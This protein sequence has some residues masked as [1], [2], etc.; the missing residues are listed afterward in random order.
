MRNKKIRVKMMKIFFGKNKKQHHM[1]YVIDQHKIS[2]KGF[3]LVELIVVLTISTILLGLT[4]LGIIAWQDWSTF[5]KQNEY[6]QSLFVAAQNQLTEYGSNG[7]LESVANEM[8][9]PTDHS[10]VVGKELTKTILEE[11]V[12]GEKEDG[13]VAHYS[14][15]AIWPESVAKEKPELYQDKIV[16]ITADATQYT[17]YLEDPIAF[18]KDRKNEQAYW[19]FEL[20]GEYIYDSSILEKGAISIEFTPEDGQVF[21]AFYSE[22]NQHFMYEG[23]AA[24]GIANLCDRS[25]SARRKKMVGFYGV[26]SLY[27]STDNKLIQA[28]ISKLFLHNADTEYLTFKL[29]KH[30]EA[31]QLL[32]YDVT[33]YEDASNQQR[34]SFTLDGTKIKNAEHAQ[35]SVC[36][37][38]RNEPVLD[39]GAVK[40]DGNGNVIYKTEG[41]S[42]G[43]FPILAYIEK[44]KTVRILFDAADVQATT[45]LYKQDLDK[46]RGN[47]AYGNAKEEQFET[48]TQVPLREFAGT[49][50]FF[51]FGIAPTDIYVSV[52][53]HGTGFKDTNTK[54]SNTKNSVFESQSVAQGAD[55]KQYAFGV[56]NGRHLY[57]IRYLEDLT[58]EQQASVTTDA[59]KI[60]KVSFALEGDIDF[61]KFQREDR[62]L[63]NSRVSYA[64]L[65]FP[66]STWKGKLVDI[67]KTK[68]ILNEDI[69]MIETA[70]DGS[71][72]EFASFAQLRSKDVLDGK[73]KTISGIYISELSNAYYGVYTSSVGTKLEIAEKKP[74]GL[75]NINLGE[76]KDLSLDHIRVSGTDMIGGFCGVNA[77]VAS[78]LETAN[79]NQKSK[80]TG[81]SNVGGLIGFQLPTSKQVEIKGLKNRV[82]VEGVKAVGGILGMVRNEFSGI[83]IAKIPGYSS[84][85]AAV[86]SK[87]EELNIQI[88]ECENYGSVSG[89][90]RDQIKGLWVSGDIDD[91]PV[92][93]ETAGED[94]REIRSTEAGYVGGIVGYC[95]NQFKTVTSTQDDTSKIQVLSCVSSPELDE[96]TLMSI[97]EDKTVDPKGYTKLENKQNGVYIGG[98]VGYNHYGQIRMCSTRAEK[99]KEGYLFGYRYVGGIVGLN[100]GPASGII[101]SN[102]AENEKGTNENHIVAY[103][104]AGGIT[105]CNANVRL[106]DKDGNDISATKL[107][108]EKLTTVL[109]PDSNRSLYVKIDNWINKG[110]V[111]ATNQYSGGITGYNA[112]MIFGCNSEVEADVADR[113]FATLYSGDYAGGV[114]GYN[115]GV[116]GNTV[117][118]IADNA[119]DSTVKTVGEKFSTV[120]YVKGHN[121]VG[122]IV[123]YNDVDSILEDYEIASGY[124]LGDAGSCFVGGY[125]GLNASIDLLMDQTY[126]KARMIYSNPNKVEGSYC[127]GGNIG[128]NMINTNGFTGG[129][130]GTQPLSSSKGDAEDSLAGS[131]FGGVVG[132]LDP[133]VTSALDAATRNT[134]DVYASFGEFTEPSAPGFSCKGKLVIHNSEERDICG[135][136][137]PVKGLPAGT[138]IAFSNDEAQYNAQNGMIFWKDKA[139]CEI[140]TATKEISFTVTGKTLEAVTKAVATL[141]NQNGDGKQTVLYALAGD[142]VQ[143][144]YVG[145]T[146]K[147]N[148]VVFAYEK[149]S[150]DK[151]TRTLKIKM[152]VENQTDTALPNGRIDFKIDKK[153]SGDSAY[154]STSVSAEQHNR[155]AVLQKTAG[156]ASISVFVGEEKG[157]ILE[158]NTKETIYLV[159]HFKNWGADNSF[160][161]NFEQEVNVDL[162]FNNVIY[163]GDSKDDSIIPTPTPTPTPTPDPEQ[164]EEL[165]N[166][167]TYF[168][169]DNFLGTLEGEEFV[170]GF[171]GYNMMFDAKQD[172]EWITGDADAYRGGVF[173]LQKNIVKA[174][175]DID[176]KTTDTQTRLVAKKD[177]LDNLDKVLDAQA[178]KQI[179][180]P[181]D[182]QIYIQG[183]EAAPTTT[184]FGKITGQIFVGGVL[185]YNDEETHLF[186]KHVE[187]ATPILASQA[188]RVDKEQIIG[189]DENQNDIYRDK[190]Y[191]GKNKTYTYSYVGGIVG[192]VTRY[193]TVDNCYNSSTGDVQTS[194]TY[195]GGL[196]EINE[197]KLINCKASSFGSSVTDYVGGICGLN[198]ALINN[199]EIT[200]K[201]ISGR[202]MVGGIVC[203]NFGTVRNIT[204]TKAKLLVDGDT[205]KEGVSGMYAAYNGKTGSIELAEA[206]I[207]DMDVKSGG[208]YVGG[209]VGYNEGD[210]DNLY[211]TEY[212]T[213]NATKGE[214][215]KNVV[216][217]GRIQGYQVV[218]G[219]IGCNNNKD[220]K[221]IVYY[222][223]NASVIAT[224]GDAGGIIGENKSG[225]SIM[226]CVNDATVAATETGNAGGITSKNNS[227]I[228]SCYDFKA[229]TSPKGMCGGITAVNQVNGRITECIVR[230][231]TWKNISFISSVCVG[232]IAAEN[233]GYVSNNQMEKVTVTNY[234]TDKGTKI[235]IIVGNNTKNGLVELTADGGVTDCNAI[236]ETDESMAGGV[237]GFNNGRILGQ[238]ENGKITSIVGCDIKLGAATYASIGGVAGVNT[239][240]IRDISVDADI[241]GNKGSVRKEEYKLPSNA[242]GYGGIAGVSGYYTASAAKK[243]QKEHGDE[244]YP[245]QIDN[246][247]F[248]GI[249]H[250]IGSSGGTASIGGIAG[251]NGY[252]S[253]ITRTYLG[254][255]SA[256]DNSETTTK[257]YAGDWSK[258]N[259]VA[260]TDKTSHSRIAGITGENYGYITDC[261]SQAYAK[262]KTMDHVEIMGFAGETA[263]IAAYDFALVS[264][265]KD[266]DG[267]IYKVTTSKDWNIEQRCADNDHGP[268]GIVGIKKSTDT[269]CYLENY[270]NITSMYPSNSKA[271]GY[272]ASVE[273]YEIPRIE[274]HHV[275]NFGNITG[276]R[277]TGGMIGQI[278]SKGVSFSECENYGAVFSETLHAGGLVGSHLDSTAGLEFRKCANH[279][280]IHRNGTDAFG[281]GGFVGRIEN[282]FKTTYY[283]GD[284]VN[285]GRVYADVATN[286]D[287]AGD[288]VG[289][290]SGETETTIN[291]E[292]CRN[293]NT[294]KDKANG[295][296]GK[297]GNGQIFYYKCFDNSNNVTTSADYTPFAGG[298]NGLRDCYYIDEDSDGSSFDHGEY[299]VYCGAYMENSNGFRI[300]TEGN[301]EY[302]TVKNVAPYFIEPNNTN[303]LSINSN[304][305]CF[306]IT[307]M[308]DN[309]SQG[310][311]AFN[312]YFWNGVK[313]L[314]DSVKQ[315]AFKATYI[316]DEEG[317]QSEAIVV[318]NAI[319]KF[320]Y[321][322]GKCV[323][324]NPSKNKK[325]IRLRMEFVNKGYIISYRGFSY[326][327]V[328]ATDREVVLQTKS[329]QRDVS[330]GVQTTK[331]VDGKTSDVSFGFNRKKDAVYPISI[332]TQSEYFELSQSLFMNNYYT[333]SLTESAKVDRWFDVNF[334][335]YYG[336]GHQGMKNFVFDL[337]NNNNNPAAA[338]TSIYTYYYDYEVTF[339]DVNGKT[340]TSPLVTDAAGYDLSVEGQ[341]DVN[342]NICSSR[343]VVKVPTSGSDALNPKIKEIKLHI[344]GTHRTKVDN[345]NQLITETSLVN[346]NVDLRFRGFSWTPAGESEAVPMVPGQ[347]IVNK[348]TGV[349]IPYANN[350]Q[351]YKAKVFVAQEPTR[352]YVYLP[353]NSRNGFE[354]DYKTNVPNAESVYGDQNDYDDSK[355]DDLN[356]GSRIDTYLD[357][358]KK[359][360][361]L[362]LEACVYEQKLD[363][364]RNVKLV[365][366]AGNYLLLWDD[367]ST[368]YAQGYEVNYQVKTR[369]G[370]VV[371]E[372]GPQ[373]V[374]LMHKVYG[375][376]EKAAVHNGYLIPIDNSWAENGYVITAS[377][378]AISGYHLV[379]GPDGVKDYRPDYACYDSDVVAPDQEVI[380]KLKLPT[381]KIHFEIVSGNRTTV[382]LDNYDEYEELGATDCTIKVHYDTSDFNW[383]LKEDGPYR[384]PEFYKEADGTKTY[385]C[386]AIPNEEL[387]EYFVDSE[388]Y[389]N[390]TEF[391]GNN[392]LPGKDM[393]C[394]TVFKG[395]YG[396]EPSNMSY[397]I[398]FTLQKLD[399]YQMTDISA[400][401]EEVGAT[402]V[403][404]NEIT[405]TANSSSGL[406]GGKL[407]LTSQLKNLPI[408]LFDSNLPRKITV[409]A[410]P[411]RSQFEWVHYGHEVE[412]DEELRLDGTVEENQEKLKSIYDTKYIKKEETK[413][414]A[415]CI[416]DEEKSDLK[417]GYLLQL[418]ADG[419]YKILY[420]ALI[421]LSMEAAQTRHETE[422]YREYYK[423]DVNYRIY[424]NAFVESNG[425]KKVNSADFQEIFWS[426]VY[427]S[428]YTIA[429]YGDISKTTE[430]ENKFVLDVQPEPIIED[431]VHMQDDQGRD[432][433]TFAWDK[434]YKDVACYNEAK[435][436]YE[437]N[438][439]DYLTAAS[440]EE[441][442][443]TWKLFCDNLAY[444]GLTT[445]TYSTLSNDDK[446]R[447][448][449]A[450][451]SNYNNAEYVV[452]LLGT[453]LDGEVVELA[454]E[455]AT[456]ASFI[457]TLD[458]KF[459]YDGMRATSYAV[460]EHVH[461]FT[462]TESK[463]TNYP[464]LT[465]RIERLGSLKTYPS[466]NYNNGNA[467]EDTTYQSTYIL[468]RYTETSLN[469]K[470]RLGTISKPN[471]VMKNDNGQFE[472]SSL[473]YTVKWG[474]IT[475]VRQLDDLGG[476]LITVK[477][478]ENSTHEVTTKTHYYY[479]EELGNPSVTD[480]IGL[481]K[482]ALS[483]TGV[484]R[485]IAA[486]EY[487]KN[488]AER[489]TDIDLSDYNTGDMITISVKAIARKQANYYEDGPDGVETELTIPSRLKVPKLDKLEFVSGDALKA[490][491]RTYEDATATRKSTHIDEGTS[492]VAPDEDLPNTVTMDEYRKGWSFVYQAN[493][494]SYKD[495]PTVKITAAIA[496]FDEKP[497]GADTDVTTVEAGDDPGESDGKQYWNTGAYATLYAKGDG[498]SLGYANKG[499]VNNIN[500]VVNQLE[501]YPGE[502]AGKWLKI[503]IKAESTTRI[504]SQWSDQDGEREATENYKWIHIPKLLLDEPKLN[505]SDCEDS[506]EDVTP[507]T[508]Y[509][510]RG[511]LVEEKPESGSYDT[512]LVPAMEMKAD[513]LAR[514]YAMTIVGK[515][516][517]KDS[518]T[519]RPVYK[520][521]LQRSYKQEND[522]SVIDFTW[523]VYLNAASEYTQIEKAR[524]NALLKN[525]VVG[526]VITR[527]DGTE[528]TIVACEADDQAVYVGN[529]GADLGTIELSDIAF[530]IG[531]DALNMTLKLD[532]IQK[533]E[534]EGAFRMV[535]P[536]ILTV[537]GEPTERLDDSYI[538]IEQMM[539]YQWIADAD[540]TSYAMG[541]AS[542]YRNQAVLQDDLSTNIW[543]KK[544]STLDETDR[545]SWLEKLEADLLEEKNRI[546]GPEDAV[547]PEGFSEFEDDSDT[548]TTVSENTL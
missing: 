4:A 333:L 195:T 506:S 278:R 69:K 419:S 479:V 359:I 362:M 142:N 464:K 448:M 476:Y 471:V 375:N 309:D 477:A 71:N 440:A 108:P 175:E 493:D 251:I 473:L 381:P 449:N 342:G 308:Y 188:V 271:G 241:E 19:V 522:K 300:E 338:K 17:S 414:S 313:T 287:T 352:T 443:P 96:K 407:V 434:Y 485:E 305:P 18:K 247:T 316:Y 47:A 138:S 130:K 223:N 148:G 534:T 32:N 455:K 257:I 501:S 324:K 275:K 465:A 178:T 26:D 499:T 395:F 140:T 75:F 295:F 484:L 90:N 174:F 149:V 117:R 102:E 207:T 282:S 345:K 182:R 339:T 467:R 542:I 336:D 145:Q 328:A 231:E 258:G 248:D 159:I 378:R 293:Y 368:N 91:N 516:V 452:T 169:T 155:K 492:Q 525:Y 497:S 367:P 482:A 237:A 41:T 213:A 88:K 296:V 56:K 365:P 474:G 536:E 343:Q 330:F 383:N 315:Y 107:D 50:S 357:I 35:L 205:Y 40:K 93:P 244:E 318:D 276:Y 30:S 163:E 311:D 531:S 363:V 1:E 285:T 509:N 349:A 353:W 417:D 211:E 408:K 317:T 65:S 401:D 335:V 210:I 246:C 216:I 98:I 373:I 89:C 156:G 441:L 529:I 106:K 503:A 369:D 131:A 546:D 110:I 323:I 193:I 539:I 413:P 123:G 112:G 34:L 530:A 390:L 115:N 109:I 418:Q 545:Q 198:K 13:S 284:C 136:K 325:P 199:C 62:Q 73:N 421:E 44:D 294:E 288:F 366:K 513:L 430:N 139:S 428:P 409:R 486:D 61:E 70:I 410:F 436:R 197:G 173:V 5:N 164:P 95:Y 458:E 77:G 304:A 520:L 312:I 206:K 437:K 100:I 187:N 260:N 78:N 456:E 171:V 468:P 451:Y 2:R 221:A 21:A 104:Y 487:S 53:G 405:H 429:K 179:I 439:V 415:N 377:V 52:K 11:M 147:E 262:G 446:R 289:Y 515:P 143:N 527:P 387:E 526:N 218:G 281:T 382:V 128:A 469:V 16:A 83:E 457:E 158:A 519:V 424:S 113:Y 422:P 431:V 194:G 225:N 350:S 507:V 36:E 220:A 120:C 226:Y 72:C 442:F 8:I 432:V 267:T 277:K 273:Q 283:F 472:T 82:A 270:S 49:Y 358:D 152:E 462:D 222:T 535:L 303:K 254:V 180:R 463:W 224:H 236:I 116:I 326:T 256:E 444:S 504:D 38:F 505:V 118:E 528:K 331:T 122:G 252:G 27:A 494:Q 67:E 481:D 523:D 392:Q 146:G 119:H 135:W 111:I 87:P 388:I 438:S 329:E 521:Y 80:V 340:Y 55:G 297:R 181:S 459:V 203:E 480:T 134:S 314:D 364:P 150:A 517:P 153:F 402:V 319:G 348:V 374:G 372:S 186:I 81:I 470:L 269:V 126:K 266:T 63:F 274:I 157:H 132:A 23:E 423:Y 162:V 292:F 168:K 478:S 227:I 379:Y 37:V 121:Y 265:Y 354:M 371:E 9:D 92:T 170:G 391:H 537:D 239:Y 48:R 279:G 177:V 172:E 445:K 165:Y 416:W 250:A 341:P 217:E 28:K 101:G 361:K 399:T 454:R 167:Y 264:G 290:L 240:L 420:N 491:M 46:I 321:K 60:E 166:V 68:S 518:D 302:S 192:K 233:D 79:T 201:T 393:Y 133:A 510:A 230:S 298:A 540:Y 39:G 394:D 10:V 24:D 25:G 433:Y 412:L 533:T 3:T 51:R 58:Y 310:I 466:Y 20:L 31:T 498:L 301:R 299:G 12:I 144:T 404:A 447:L 386:Y 406:D 280:L 59:D 204:L 332:K 232:G 114:A 22:K 261:D 54:K 263:G 15:D 129:V 355:T 219:L 322:D 103:E 76:I 380:A 532:Y 306:D 514:G 495:E 7:K 483:E 488:G 347:G 397:E 435:N 370:K 385:Y 403:Y 43:T 124:V 243:G 42:I 490:G 234:K 33:V 97:L 154:A 99:G 141:E 229:V 268:G 291:F 6:A 524:Q 176:K 253:K 259:T 242:V 396:T 427:S 45:F 450:Y 541:N 85:I 508:V 346:Y 461:S 425:E 228:R 209:I 544:L 196:C 502:L 337:A 344:R 235:G 356:T 86:L 190:D 426:R 74:V 320:D 255:R 460:F 184:T 214:I 215:D 191:A 183:E 161:K 384:K 547:G 105:G 389:R 189:Q 14:Y 202:N 208:R 398:Q 212:H 57:N 185:G 411:Y 137:I 511:E 64:Y 548:Q 29:T 125:A 307:F 66:I 151:A 538:G 376:E 245:A 286:R 489:E 84:S 453:T 512:L 127:V 327:P 496:A 360:T 400:Y 94:A 272:A 543:V 160:E 500:S 351:K 475:D 334:R 249:V 238:V 200:R